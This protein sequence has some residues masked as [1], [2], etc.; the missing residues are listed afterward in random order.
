MA[1]N[2][3]EQIEQLLDKKLSENQAATAAKIDQL[4][5]RVDEGFANTATTAQIDTLANHI[6]K[7]KDDLGSQLDEQD[8]TLGRIERRLNT[9]LDRLDD[10]GTRIERLEAKTAH[11]PAPP[12][13]RQ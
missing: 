1:D 7:V 6:Q 5:K 4:A 3:L 10:H 13:G 2:S 8:Q 12:R 9:D 11:L